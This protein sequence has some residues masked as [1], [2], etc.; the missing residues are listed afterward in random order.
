LRSWF[1]VV[2]LK[3][4]LTITSAF[5]SENDRTFDSVSA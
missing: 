1:V 3:C 2:V 5:F 4:P